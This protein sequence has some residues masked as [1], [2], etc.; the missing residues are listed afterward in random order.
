MPIATISV[1]FASLA[2]IQAGTTTAK[3]I[4]PS[5]LKSALQSGASMYDLSLKG[6]QLTAPLSA[7]NGTAALPSITFASDVNTGIYRPAADTLGFV[8][9]GV[10]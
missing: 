4:N 5:N 3:S 8:E 6:L 7:A 9:V 1:N 10:S 2:E